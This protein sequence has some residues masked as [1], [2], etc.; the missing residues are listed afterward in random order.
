M[1]RYTLGNSYSHPM[2]FTLVIGD[3]ATFWRRDQSGHLPFFRGAL[4]AGIDQYTG[5]VHRYGQSQGCIYTTD[6]ASRPSA[7]GEHHLERTYP[8]QGELEWPR[9]EPGNELSS[10]VQVV[11][12]PWSSS[13]L[14]LSLTGSKPH[15]CTCTDVPPYPGLNPGMQQSLLF[16]AWSPCNLPRQQ[17]AHCQVQSRDHSW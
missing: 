12:V 5:W 1:A 14:S 4:T 2:H 3:N 11:K 17:L 16:S 15:G 7:R 8:E 10:S 6:A 13:I 9:A